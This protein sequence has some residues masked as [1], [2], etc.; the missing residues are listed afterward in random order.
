VEQVIR[1]TAKLAPNPKKCTFEVDRV[2]SA[3]GTV[4]FSAKAETE[5]SEVAKRLF[6]LPAV[7]AVVVAGPVVTV[8]QDG[9][10]AWATLAK[11]CGAAIRAAIS[12]GLPLV[13]KG[14]VSQPPAEEVLRE[15]VQKVLDFEVNPAVASHGGFIEIVEIRDKDV[16]LKMG[17]GCQGARRRPRPSIR[18]SRR[19][20]KTRCPKS[21]RSSIRPITRRAA[22]PTSARR[23]AVALDVEGDRRL[24]EQV[25]FLAGGQRAPS[26]IPRLGRRDRSVV[27]RRLKRRDVPRGGL[28]PYERTSV[29]DASKRE[30]PLVGAVGTDV[31]R[32]G[33]ERQF[34][35]VEADA[36][37]GV[38]AFRAGFDAEA[39]RFDARHAAFSRGS[40][41]RRRAPRETPRFY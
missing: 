20:S 41:A 9:S 11:D 13:K 6:E 34:E 28:G 18:A 7:A 22:A 35:A 4:Y 2:L 38:G 23:S 30:S 40:E 21:A 17:G 37:G 36:N 27:E 29:A 5:G 16:V 24:L 8:T 25:P 14:Y 19:R 1:I 3:E 33:L 12:S 26:E 31:A 10:A 32:N 39:D 15:K